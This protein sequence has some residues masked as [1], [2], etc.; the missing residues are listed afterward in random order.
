[1]S[2]L[3]ALGA[4]GVLGAALP[5]VSGQMNMSMANHV[6]RVQAD[7]EELG[8][9]YNIDIAPRR[10]EALKTYHNQEI[11]A[12]GDID[13]DGLDQQGKVDYLMLQAYHTR[14]LNKPGASEVVSG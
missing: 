7:L 4:L 14:Q 8:E 3:Q 5:F 6:L 2:P 10:F 9:F 12:A 13:F 11:E 1:M